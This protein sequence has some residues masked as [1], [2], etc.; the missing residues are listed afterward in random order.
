VTVEGHASV[1]R[2][3]TPDDLRVVAGR[4]LGDLLKDAYVDSVKHGG[5]IV[6]LEVEK[7]IDVDF[8]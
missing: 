3:R 8:R 1:V 2:E 7:I 6:R 4:Y 5:V